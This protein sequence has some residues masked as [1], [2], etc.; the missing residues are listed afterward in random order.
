MAYFV[1]MSEVA[2]NL[3]WA[4]DSWQSYP[5]SQQPTYNDPAA[6]DAV[7]GRLASLPPLV[8]SWEVEAL[9]DH[10]AKAQAGEAFVLQGGDCAET[11]AD[12]QSDKIGFDTSRCYSWRA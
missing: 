8:T 6:V 3:N 5:A 1:T 11:F 10:I 7:L 12:C 2:K 9:R 4:P